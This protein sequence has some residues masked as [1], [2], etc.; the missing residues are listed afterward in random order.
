M[1]SING[2]YWQ[3]I[4]VPTGSKILRRSD[5]SGTVGVTDNATKTVYLSELLCWALLKKVLCHEIC[6]CACFSYDCSFP[7]ETE[8][9][10]ADFLATYGREVLSVAD[11][12]FYQITKR[13]VIA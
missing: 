12:V 8:E 6:H 5:G 10:L 2:I 4:F 7:L 11:T 3:I 9:L 1:F 13:E